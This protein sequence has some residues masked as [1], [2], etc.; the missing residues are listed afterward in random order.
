MRNEEK[1]LTGL[2]ALFLAACPFIVR[3]AL[4]ECH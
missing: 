3:D 1:L 4:R 2:L